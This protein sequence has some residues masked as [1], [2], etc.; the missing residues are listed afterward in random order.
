MGYVR[1]HHVSAIQAHVSS[2][3]E[4]VVT[5]QEMSSANCDIEMI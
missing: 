2:K 3:L 1:V 4:F 5:L